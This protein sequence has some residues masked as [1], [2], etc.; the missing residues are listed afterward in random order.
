MPKN[1][2]RLRMPEKIRIERQRRAISEQPG[3]SEKEVDEL[4]NTVRQGKAWNERFGKR[5]DEVMATLRK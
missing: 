3:Y 4:W 2:L 1:V 5:A